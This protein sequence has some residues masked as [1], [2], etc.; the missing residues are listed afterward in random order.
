MADFENFDVLFASDRSFAYGEQTI[1]K[2]LKSRRLA[3]SELLI[4]KLLETLGVERRKSAMST[5]DL[6]CLY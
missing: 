5:G 4:D 1:T 6:S 2:I 3:D